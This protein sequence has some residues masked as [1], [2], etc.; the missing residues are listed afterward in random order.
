MERSTT[1]SKS[2]GVQSHIYV[3]VRENGSEF[4]YRQFMNSAQCQKC[5][6]IG[7][8][9]SLTSPFSLHNLPRILF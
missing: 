7:H 9:N 5:I 2:K 8:Q 3:K 6:N 4:E 1:N